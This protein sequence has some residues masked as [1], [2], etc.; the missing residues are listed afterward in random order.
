MKVNKG[1]NNKQASLQT[2]PFNSLIIKF[3][4]C[5]YNTFQTLTFSCLF[6]CVW[7]GE[8]ERWVSSKSTTIEGKQTLIP[9]G[10]RLNKLSQ[11]GL[12]DMQKN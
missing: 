5:F 7:R 4:S 3:E 6:Q 12:L 11:C 2:T 9:A 8:G 10:V 1:V